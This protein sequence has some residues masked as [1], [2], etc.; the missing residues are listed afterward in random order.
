VDR[1]ELKKK[2]LV[3]DDGEEIKE[4]NDK[5]TAAEESKDDEND[6]ESSDS[7]ISMESAAEEEVEVTQAIGVTATVSPYA[8]LAAY[9]A[10]T[11]DLTL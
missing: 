9:C 6:H 10:K 4:T 5:N 11:D 3:G 1:R 2:K 8:E 7:D